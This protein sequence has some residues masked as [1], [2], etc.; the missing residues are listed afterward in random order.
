FKVFNSNA[1]PMEVSFITAD[2]LGQN[3]SLICKTGDNLRQ[4]M[5]VLQIVSLLD[6]MWRQ[7]GLDMRMVTYRCIS[8]GRDQGLVEV[9]RDA[10]TL[11]KIHQEWG[12]SG[13]LREDTLEKWFHMRNKTKEDYEK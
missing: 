5:L 8:T 11:A 2:P 12:L 9:V 1:A 3:Y 4:D 7:E 13:A 10:V 6:R